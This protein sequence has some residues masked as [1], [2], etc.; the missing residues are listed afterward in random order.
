MADEKPWK[1]SIGV[2]EGEGGTL[3]SINSP[4]EQDQLF[5]VASLDPSAS[6]IF[7]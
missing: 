5:E 4:A 7:I 1:T 2:C 6:G 3:V